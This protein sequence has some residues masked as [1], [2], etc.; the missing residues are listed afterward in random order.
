MVR[1]IDFPVVRKYADFTGLSMSKL[2]SLLS[3]QGIL[4][5]FIICWN[6]LRALAFW[7]CGKVYERRKIVSEL[8]KFCV[9][10]G[11]GSGG[12]GVD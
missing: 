1:Y 3:W 11:A 9:T 8:C 5:S 6:C 10:V 12:R 2:N 7:F 4:V